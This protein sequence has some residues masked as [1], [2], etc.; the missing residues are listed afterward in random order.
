MTWF[1]ETGAGLHQRYYNLIISFTCIYLM[2]MMICVCVCVVSLFPSDAYVVLYCI[3]VWWIITCAHTVH[4]TP[5]HY[6]NLWKLPLYAHICVLRAT[7]CLYVYYMAT[8]TLTC[9]QI[10]LNVWKSIMPTN[11][12]LNQIKRHHDE[13]IISPGY[14]SHTLST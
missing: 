5:H 12:Q 6:C 4:T 10:T 13:W 8:L 2:M 1:A 9:R 7:I 3:N 14:L 11:Q